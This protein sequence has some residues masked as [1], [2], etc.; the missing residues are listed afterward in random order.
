MGMDSIGS[1]LVLGG[2]TGRVRRCILVGGD[3]SLGIDFV[4][5]SVNCLCLVLVDQDGNCQLSL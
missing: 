3:G 5:G 2:T 4:P 1:H